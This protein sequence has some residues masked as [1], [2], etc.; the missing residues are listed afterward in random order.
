MESGKSIDHFKNSTVDIIDVWFYA[1]MESRRI[2]I[3]FLTICC[4][5]KWLHFY[6]R[7]RWGWRQQEAEAEGTN[8]VHEG[9]G[10]SGFPRNSHVSQK[11]FRIGH[12]SGKIYQ[13]FIVELIVYTFFLCWLKLNQFLTFLSC[14]Q[15][16]IFIKC[17]SLSYLK[18]IEDKRTKQDRS[19]I[20]SLVC[21]YEDLRTAWDTYWTGP[22]YY[23]HRLPWFVFQYGELGEDVWHWFVHQWSQYAWLQQRSRPGG[24]S[25]V[26][27]T[28][29]SSRSG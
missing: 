16:M 19:S 4:N 1:E 11:I 9:M 27:R 28:Q 2:V 18:L 12:F 20:I 24:N 21:K 5:I 3:Y 17:I 23:V 13:L 29:T 25:T 10:H 22:L 15:Y 8:D 7:R 6:F 26:S 14:A